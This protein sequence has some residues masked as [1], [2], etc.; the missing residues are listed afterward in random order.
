MT[1]IK[2]QLSEVRVSRAKL[3]RV[4]AAVAVAR[5]LDAPPGEVKS[6][7]SDSS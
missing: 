3:S 1:K 7:P 5:V 4:R 2:N 6:D